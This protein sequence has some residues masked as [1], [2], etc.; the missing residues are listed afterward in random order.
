LQGSGERRKN[1]REREATMNIPTTNFVEFDPQLERLYIELED[2]A[3]PVDPELARIYDEKS[4]EV[5]V[6][7]EL[8]SDPKSFESIPQ[9]PQNRF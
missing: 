6:A 9:T 2:N 4:V 5:P 3:Y 1:S 7:V 8:P